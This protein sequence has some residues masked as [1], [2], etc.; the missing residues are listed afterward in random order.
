M[1]LAVVLVA[2]IAVGSAEARD[3]D[4]IVDTSKTHQTI[5]GF[6]T[7]W[8]YWAWLPQYDDPKFFD[9]AVN[10]LGISMVDEI[11]QDSH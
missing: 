9:L 1:S 10:D 2:A 8:T 7:M 11:R 6:G 5:E 3:V 4:V